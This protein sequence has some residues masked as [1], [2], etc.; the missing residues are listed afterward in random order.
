MELIKSWEFNKE[1]LDRN[2]AIILKI[3]CEF[4]KER[5]P[6]IDEMVDAIDNLNRQILENE[7]S[8][9]ED[10]EEKFEECIENGDFACMEAFV[11]NILEKF[12][13]S[14]ITS[15]EFILG[16]ETDEHDVSTFLLNDCQNVINEFVDKDEFV[17]SQGTDFTQVF[18][19]PDL[20]VKLGA[21]A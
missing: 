11:V 8:A 20:T 21:G 5:L 10:V 13:H 18:K 1:L 14:I 9:G 16:S 12:K 4:L 15:Q 3:Y 17:I 19:K 2:I 6:S 7:F